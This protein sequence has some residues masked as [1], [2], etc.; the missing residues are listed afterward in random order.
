MKTWAAFLFVFGVV[1]LRVGAAEGQIA[2]RVTSNREVVETV[3]LDNVTIRD[4]NVTAT[5]VNHSR[6][7]LRGIKVLVRHAWLW[8][9][10]QHPGADN[11]ARAVYYVHPTDLPSGER[12]AFTYRPSPPLPDRS[13]GRFTTTVEI[14]GFEEVGF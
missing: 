4:G 12:A 13:D 10:E 2:E 7:A 14:V 5:L 11:P 3:T 6:Y 9:N 1:A 8:R